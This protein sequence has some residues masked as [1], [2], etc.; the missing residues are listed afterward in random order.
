M[1]RYYQKSEKGDWEVAQEPNPL[2]PWEFAKQHNASRVSIMAVSHDLDVAD[3]DDVQYFGF[4]AVDIDVAGD[5]SA[6]ISSAKEFCA[7]VISYGVAPEVLEIHCSGSKG[8]HIYIHPHILGIKK[9]EKYLPLVYKKLAALVFVP[10]LDFQVFS[11][12]KGNL[13]R[14]CEARRPDGKYKVQISYSELQTLTVE[15]YQQFTSATRGVIPVDFS[16]VE[17]VQSL[18][19]LVESCRNLVK[20]QLK[21]KENPPDT[22]FDVSIFG[23]TPPP[24]VEA[25]AQGKRSTET[26]FNQIAWNVANFTARSNLPKTELESLQA[27]VSEKCKSDSGKP[28]SERRND[29]VA[30]HN[31]VLADLSKS[32]FACGSILKTI[33]TRPCQDCKVFKDREAIAASSP[34]LKLFEKFGQYYSDRDATVQVTTFTLKRISVLLDEE[35]GK[36]ISST[37]LLT[38]PASAQSHVIEDFQEEA[39][40]SKFNFKTALVGVSGASFFGT[41]NDVQRLKLT[42][43]LAEVTSGMEQNL[44]ETQTTGLIYR[45]RSGPVSARDKDHRGRFTYVEADYTVNDVGVVNTHRYVG[46]HQPVPKLCTTKDW[47]KPIANKQRVSK[48]FQL[49]MKC[50]DPTTTSQ[51]LGWYLLSHLRQHVFQ[52]KGSGILLCISG[53]AGTGKNQ[54]IALYQRLAGLEGHDADSTIEAPGNTKMPVLI[55]LSTTHTIPRIINELNPKSVGIKEYRDFMETLKAGFDS[56]A[57]SRGR[58]GGSKSSG[59]ITTRE[60]VIRAPIVTLSEEVIDNEP[61]IQHR[62][63]QV[64]FSDEGR[65]YGTPAFMELREDPDPLTDIAAYLVKSAMETTCYEIWERIKNTNIPEAVLNSAINDRLKGG[66]TDI[67]MAYDW[68]IEKLKDPDQGITPEALEDLKNMKQHFIANLENNYQQIAKAAAVTEVDKILEFFA[69]MANEAQAAKGSPWALIKG[70]H[71]SV[72]DGTL[73]LDAPVAYTNLRR[74]MQEVPRIQTAVAFIS[75]CRSMPY[76]ISDAAI[77]QDMRVQGR[78]VLALSV[79]KMLESGISAGFFQ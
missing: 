42:V 71:Y 13:F 22:V 46:P 24:C 7:K 48:A 23:S 39:W 47:D 35:T 5:L 8:L 33:S 1:L 18:I 65:R 27:R 36:T 69:M 73:F 41:D 72:E 12:G 43:E 44:F 77:A 14:P 3:I 55:A 75:A 51:V 29:L 61:A 70:E 26:N 57:A 38:L 60:W 62:S 25:L 64:T 68:A 66:Y 76:Y 9:P 45:K 79:D 6:A 31:Y 19:S 11:V 63:I 28:T 21:D 74:W 58:L 20:K 67:L 37:L 17:P 16:K 4:F 54:L 10:G 2:Q 15:Q 52:V 50:N 78:K 34:N 59:G 56:R 40:I 53:V 30:M 32:R 49:L